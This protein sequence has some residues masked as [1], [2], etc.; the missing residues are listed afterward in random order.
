M[1]QR[2]QAGDHGF[3]LSLGQLAAFNELLALRLPGGRVPFQGSVFVVKLS[4]ELDQFIDFF[5]ESLKLSVLHARTAYLQI[6]DGIL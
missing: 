2:L 6:I 1:L 4:A 3:Y 5:G